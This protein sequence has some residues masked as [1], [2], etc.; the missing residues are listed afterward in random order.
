MAA[1]LEY[2][3]RY[4]A[5]KVENVSPHPQLI[6]SEEQFL[7]LRLFTDFKQRYLLVFKR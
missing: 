1:V 2:G 3:V 4:G 5:S 6:N 7:D